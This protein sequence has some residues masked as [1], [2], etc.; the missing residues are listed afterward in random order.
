MSRLQAGVIEP[1]L[2][3]VGY[4]EVVHTAVHG[5]GE[6]SDRVDVDV[7]ETLPPVLADAAL[8]ERV[9]ANIVDNAVTASPETTRVRVQ[10]REVDGGDA[11]QIVDQGP[12]IPPEERARVLEPFHRAGDARSATGVGLGLAVA[13]G[14]VGAMHGEL[15]LD[16]TP[17]GGL[18]AVVTFPRAG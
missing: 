6:G 18:T 14:F 1:Q 9:V 13:R 7:P 2:R 10:A 17:G 5:L 4:E 8:L 11:L 15:V 3:A 12:G 16:D